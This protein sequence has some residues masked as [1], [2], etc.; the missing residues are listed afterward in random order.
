MGIEFS[1]VSF[2]Y[3]I[4]LAKRVPVCFAVCGVN[5]KVC[6]KDEF[7]ALIGHTGS[8]K[9]TIAQIMNLLLLPTRGTVKHNIE[10]KEYLIRK[11]K[12]YRQDTLKYRKYLLKKPKYN[13]KLKPIR[14]FAGLVF[15]FP[16]YQLFEETVLKDIEFGP[17]NLFKDK[18]AAISAAKKT[19]DIM[20]LNDILNKSPFSLSGGQMRKVAIAGILA[21][22]P[23][24][25]ILDEPTV[26]LDPVNKNELLGFLKE[27]N[28]KY[29]KS[30]VIITHDMDIVGEYAKRAIVLKSGKVMYDGSSQELFKNKELIE[31]CHLSMPS[32][33]KILE[34]LSCKLNKDLDIYQYNI[35]DAIGEL[36]RK[37]GTQ[38][39]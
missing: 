33:V 8:G 14:K 15:Q 7:I 25:L 6:A 28:E 10:G 3:N 37:F 13:F 29:H 36:A 22:N 9:S 2:A 18:K 26:G 17:K 11:T 12:E 21:S 19:A 1:D 16:E 5:L 4:P 23:D 20:G 38:D 27:L 39:E 32:I 31:N 35:K 24:M 34:N 30:I